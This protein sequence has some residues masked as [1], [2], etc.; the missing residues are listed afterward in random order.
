MPPECSGRSH[1]SSLQAAVISGVG[2]LL[3]PPPPQHLHGQ[4]SFTPASSFHLMIC[5]LHFGFALECLSSLSRM[6]SAIFLVL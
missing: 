4:K 3:P 6:R 5:G 2:T 1:P